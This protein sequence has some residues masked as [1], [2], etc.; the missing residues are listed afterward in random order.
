MGQLGYTGVIWADGLARN[1]LAWELTHSA[2]FLG[3][4]NIMRAIPMLSLGLFAGVLADRLDRKRILAAT[5]LLT[6]LMAVLLAALLFTNSMR[7]WHLLLSTAISGGIMAFNQPAR[8]SILPDL[9]PAS[10]RPNAVSLNQIAMN[11]S[12]VL[13]PALAG[14][15]IGL[16]SVKGAYVMQ[17]ILVTVVILLTNRM[18]VPA[19]QNK[20]HQGALASLAEGLRYVRGQKVVS[21]ILIL[22]LLTAVFT[23]PLYTMLPVL[24]DDVLG[25]GAGGFGLLA[26]CIGIGALLGAIVLAAQGDVRHKGAV[27]LGAAG[28]V[29]ALVALLGL[30][31]WLIMAIPVLILI[32]VAQTTLGAVTNNALLDLT[33]DEYRGR[34]MS[35]LFLQVGFFSIGSLV[36]GIL[37]DRVGAGWALVALGSTSVV[38][39]AVQ[40]VA[41]APLRRLANRGPHFA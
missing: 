4:V 18:V 19:A 35:L 11:L 26:S 33:D 1:W 8:S 36:A 31:H 12:S 29:G 7:P 24:A 20:N 41:N 2:S 10:A 32:G 13:G 21:S 6:L 16:F 5:Q 17:I 34:V 25:M 39:A 23:L 22:S 40:A 3:L 14:V 37:A 9:V 28:L 38:L 30:S 15:V 27:I